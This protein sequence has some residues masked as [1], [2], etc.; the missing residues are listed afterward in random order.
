MLVSISDF[1]RGVSLVPT[2][3]RLGYEHRPE[4]DILDRHFFRRRRGAARTHHLSLA[5]PDSNHHRDTLAFRDAMLQD[6]G[7]AVEYGELKLRL[8]ERFPR[9]RE[10]YI[11]GKTSFVVGVLARQPR[12][13]IRIR[14]ATAQDAT[15]LS[16]IAHA[17][18]ASWGYPPEWLE[19]W[20]PQLQFTAD[21]IEASHVRVAE[22]AGQ[23]VAVIALDEPDGPVA[24]IDHLWV[25]PEYQGQGIGRALVDD[26]VR[27]AQTLG[28][29]SIKI[30]SDPGA[31]SFYERLGAAFVGEEP[32]PVAGTAR[33]LP[34][35]S[36]SIR[37]DEPSAAT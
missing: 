6:P 11:N 15:R 23:P 37:G 30:L 2:L 27:R 12:M 19:E 5:E 22:D 29:S 25:L 3:E 7:L 8:A 14:D 16:G 32:A 31:R 34:V 18:K 4:N 24:E 13:R 26:I 35:L 36:F 9:D 17:A 1:E 21:S 28:Y 20:R 33:A 10:A